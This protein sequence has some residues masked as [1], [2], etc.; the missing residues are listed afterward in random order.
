VRFIHRFANDY[1]TFL[2][3]GQSWYMLKF[4]VLSL[5]TLAALGPTG[6]SWQDPFD[7]PHRL[8]RPYLQPASDYSAGHRGVDYEIEIGEP[9]FAPADG[10]ITVSKV[11]VNRGVLAIK[12]GAGLLSELEPACSDVPVGTTVLKGEVIGWACSA[13]DAYTQHCSVDSCLHFSLRLEGKYLSPLA[14][15]GGLNPSRLLP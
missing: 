1:A 14:L 11:I 8:V 10:V 7:S 15:I 2:S 13:A 3:I 5:F 6:A 4:A 9:L 12:H